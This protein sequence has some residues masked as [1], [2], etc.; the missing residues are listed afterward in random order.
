[1]PKYQTH[2]SSRIRYDDWNQTYLSP[3]INKL[4]CN[5]KPKRIDPFLAEQDKPIWN[6]MG[7]AKISAATFP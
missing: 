6:A 4:S 2:T 3:F 5:V 1:M 7:Q